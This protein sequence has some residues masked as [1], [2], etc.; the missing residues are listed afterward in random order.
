MCLSLPGEVVSLN[1]PG[2]EV[3]TL[4]VRRWC[5]A[6]MFPELRV[7]DRVLVH[8]GLIVQRLTG[9]EARE[10]EAAFAELG[11]LPN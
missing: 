10:I 3:Q 6:L 2:A 7:G 11:V 9:E 8:A 5:N 4:G 1:G